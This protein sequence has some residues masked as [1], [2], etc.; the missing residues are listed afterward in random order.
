M[1]KKQQQQQCDDS[2]WKNFSL[3]FLNRRIFFS[4]IEQASMERTWKLL[5][6]I[7]AGGREI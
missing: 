6:E 7:K 2:G 4:I 1:W 3:P 5:R